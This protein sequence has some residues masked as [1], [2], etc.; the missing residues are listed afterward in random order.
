MM[1][2]EEFRQQTVVRILLLVA[3]MLAPSEWREEIQ[4]LA[5]HISTARYFLHDDNGN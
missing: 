5:N 1:K 3:K 4:H 2:A